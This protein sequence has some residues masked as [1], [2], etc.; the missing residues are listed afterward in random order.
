MNPSRDPSTPRGSGPAQVLVVDDPLFDE[1]RSRGYH[2]ERPE[3]LEAARRAV[4]ACAGQGIALASVDPRDATDDEIARAHD[5]AYVEALSQVSGRYAAL[6]AD[7]YIAP[8]SVRAA[9]RAAGGSIA[10]VHALL[11]AAANEG[12]RLGVALLRPPGH[13]ATRDRG[14]GFCLFNNAAIAA[15]HAIDQGGLSRVAIVDWDVHHGNGTQDTFWRDPRV[16]YVSLHQAPLYP[17]TGAVSEVGQGDGVGSTVNVPLSP[18]AADAT[19]EAA[20][21]DVVTPALE[22][23]APELV[24]VSAGYDAHERD[25]LASM[26]LSDAAY[27]MM[28][29]EI[30]RVAA[31]SAGGRVVLLLEGGYDLAAIEGSLAASI[32]ALAAPGAIHGKTGELEAGRSGGE[33]APARILAVHRDEITAAQRVVEAHR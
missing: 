2:P 5:P 16:L 13:H 17:G 10:L 22:R 14:M 18:G 6:D 11:D 33:G 20:F 32:L 4:A 31:A 7:T 28:A 23:F 19:Y 3:R 1:H 27:A 25:P 24:I 26:N 29:R 15:R 9:R 8:E 12:P 30:A 21:H